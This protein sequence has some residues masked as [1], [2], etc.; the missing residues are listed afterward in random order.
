MLAHR[1]IQ[2]CLANKLSVNRYSVY[3]VSLTVFVVCFVCLFVWLVLDRAKN[4]IKRVKNCVI[5]E[6]ISLFYLISAFF[7]NF[8]SIGKIS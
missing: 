7:F 3:D 6:K 2:S 5:L 1:L 8:S 4:Q